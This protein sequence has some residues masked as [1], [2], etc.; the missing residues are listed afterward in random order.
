MDVLIPSDQLRRDCDAR[1]SLDLVAGQHPNLDTSVSQK[2]QSALYVILQLVF[3]TSQAQKFKI[4]L[5]ILGDNGSHS[6]APPLELHAR[7]MVTLLEGLIRL[8]AHLPLGHDERPKSLP[9]HIPSL[10]FQPIVP[11]YDL[12]HDHVRPFLQE[13]DLT[14]CLV[15]NDDSHPLGLGCEREDVQN[16]E[17]KVVA[18]WSLE[19]DQGAVTENQGEANGFRPLHDSNLIWRRCLVGYG[20]VVVRYRCDLRTNG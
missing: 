14:R 17:G 18:G 11:L 3:N 12:G 9:S 16:V 7:G 15:A 5:K 4:L 19:F 13:R 8:F 6:F 1:R 2:F 10:L 20:A